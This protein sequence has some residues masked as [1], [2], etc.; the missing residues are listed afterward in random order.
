[1][2][3]EIEEI[4]AKNLPLHVGEVLK[5]RLEEATKDATRLAE[6]IK[7]VEKLER[8]NKILVEMVSE[9]DSIKKDQKATEQLKE[10]LKEKERNLQIT[11]LTLQ[12]EEANKRADLAKEFTF[13][14]F[15]NPTFKT[16]E[17]HHGM[18]PVKSTYKD[19]QGNISET[20]VPYPTTNTVTSETLQD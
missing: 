6:C 16:V 9:Q 19:Y 17:Q 3:K 14:V 11:I 20:L 18:T 10:E 4:I 2:E 13:A 12:V 1:M 5:S 15:K 8:A 7:D